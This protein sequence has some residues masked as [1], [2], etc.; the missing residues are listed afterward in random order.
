ML[1]SARGGECGSPR[2]PSGGSLPP[3]APNMRG[4]ASGEDEGEN[5]GYGEPLRDREGCSS[6]CEESVRV[7]P[8]CCSHVSLARDS[9]GGSVEAIRLVAAYVA[10]MP[11]SHPMTCALR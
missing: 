3:L 10:F 1:A 5:V 7:R 9:R 8:A 2:P 11:D 6:A 4:E